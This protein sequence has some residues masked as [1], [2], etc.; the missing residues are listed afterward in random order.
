MERISSIRLLE[1]LEYF[2]QLSFFTADLHVSRAWSVESDD[3][4]Q[5]VY[6]S[7]SME[8]KLVCIV[9]LVNCKVL[10]FIWWWVVV[11]TTCTGVVGP[12]F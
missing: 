12:V 9:L 4:E 5:K 7:S 10:L 11:E 2:M 1:D 3:V 8:K 6:P